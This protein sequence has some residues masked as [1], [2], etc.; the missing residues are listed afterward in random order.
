MAVNETVTLDEVIEYLN[1]LVKADPLAMRALICNRVPC[2]RELAEHPTCQVG[3]WQEGFH[4]GIVGVINGMFGVFGEDEEG[5]VG[6][7]PVA[8]VLDEEKGLCGF[9]RSEQFKEYRELQL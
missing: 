7:G 2:N 4:V 9:G 8:W 3:Q 5:H 1:S 6:W